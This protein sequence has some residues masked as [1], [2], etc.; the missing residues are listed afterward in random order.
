VPR[1]KHD[2]L[3]I[4]PHSGLPGAD[5][6][7]C[8]CLIVKELEDGTANIFC[9]E[10]GTLIRTVPTD[11]APQQPFENGDGSGYV[12]CDLSLLWSVQRD[13]WIQQR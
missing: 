3:P 12:Q 11:D 5:P 13:S 2:E 1:L 4:V 8:G 6:E 9:N 7:C 10:C